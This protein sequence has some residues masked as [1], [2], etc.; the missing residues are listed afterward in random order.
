MKKGIGKDILTLVSDNGID[1]GELS[2]VKDNFMPSL[3]QILRYCASAGSSEAKDKIFALMR[4]PT[5][6]ADPSRP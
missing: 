6:T 1:C 5:R 4:F 2:T 3:I